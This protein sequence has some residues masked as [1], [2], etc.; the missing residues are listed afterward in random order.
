MSDF[1]YARY[2]DTQTLHDALSSIYTHDIPAI[3]TFSGAWGALALGANRYGGFAHYEDAHHLCAV[4]GAP[5]L[6][7]RSNAFL[8]TEGGNEGTQA[9][10]RRYL[11]GALYWDEEVSGPFVF[12]L[13]DKAAQTLVYVTDLM[14]FIPVYRYGEGE[15][16]GTHVDAL[17]RAA[18][19]TEQID[20]VSVG[21]FILNHVVTFPYTTYA[22]IRQSE[23]AAHYYGAD[24]F[25]YWQPLETEMFGSLD[26]AA[27]ALRKALKQYVE[28]VCAG[29]DQVGAFVSPGEDSRAVLGML[30]SHVLI[31]GFHYGR[32]IPREEGIV[33][34]VCAAY[35]AHLNVLERDAYFYLDILPEATRLIGSM[36]QYSHAH[37]LGLHRDWDLQKYRAVFGGY[38]ADS[39][40]KGVYARKFKAYG[41]LRFLPEFER[42]GENRTQALR[43]NYI[44]PEILQEIDRRRREHFA[45]LEAL[46]PTSAHEWFAFWPATMR[47]TIVNFHT[48]RR[49]FCSYEPFFCNASVKIAAGVAVR[50]KLNRR[51]F[52]RV[53]RPF[54]RPSRHI[55]HADGRLPY[56][57]FWANAPLV[58]WQKLSQLLTTS[59]ATLKA[60]W[61]KEE[62]PWMRRRAVKSDSRWKDAFDA[63]GAGYRDLEAL[64]DNTNAQKKLSSRR[65]RNVLQVLC[66]LDWRRSL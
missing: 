41:L 18:E 35:G 19:C 43:S 39:L 37:V 59:V 13:I 66:W 32:G 50:W 9:L 34:E 30:P 53:V 65:S 25:H 23:P 28:A 58:L 29:M 52:H 51:L 27:E 45:R 20:W 14:L 42:K 64:I 12:V 38:L 10:M 55:A 49:L 17:A 22:S 36:H 4:I 54:L 61:H 33:R 46:R 62:T 11:E 2:A 1:L 8:G 24:F 16:I 44:K 40:H 63:Y 57:S 15:M 56:C 3:A 5:L 48:T 26:G 31:E 7:W 60:Y 6:E 21:D 47:M